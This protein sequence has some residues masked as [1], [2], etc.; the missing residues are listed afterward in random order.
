MQQI[1]C[2]GA[3]GTSLVVRSENGLDHLLHR[4]TLSLSWNGMYKAVLALA[5]L[6]MSLG[7]QV[8]ASQLDDAVIAAQK[9][10]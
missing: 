7:G 6:L 3:I 2:G 4:Q 8:R 5:I 9:G 10:D 1:N